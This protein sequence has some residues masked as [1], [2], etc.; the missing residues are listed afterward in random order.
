MPLYVHARTR[1]CTHAH[2][3]ASER[4]DKQPD[5]QNDAHAHA[6]AR[7]RTDL[8]HDEHLAHAARV[9][10]L[11]LRVRVLPCSVPALVPAA[12]RARGLVARDAGAR[13]FPDERGV[14]REL[15]VDAGGEERAQRVADGERAVRVVVAAFAI[16]FAITFAFI[17]AFAFVFVFV[18]VFAN[19][20]A[21]ASVSVAVAAAVVAAAAARGV[22]G[23]LRGEQVVLAQLP[24]LRVARDDALVERRRGGA[25]EERGVRREVGVLHT[26]RR[27]EEA[28]RS[29]RGKRG[30]GRGTGQGQGQG[31]GDDRENARER[32]LP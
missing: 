17:F 4:T 10:L 19:V 26:R 24:R 27:G 7:G 18:F 5:S 11:L 21:V 9:L 2:T 30:E 12:V 3:R 23:R 13:R 6:G 16:T 8:S 28:K 29:A 14:A 31:Q 15:Y 22:R 20:A 1:I 25:G 32:H